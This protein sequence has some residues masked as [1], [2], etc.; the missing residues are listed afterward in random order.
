RSRKVHLPLCKLA[1]RISGRPTEERMKSI[2]CHCQTG[3][4]VE[5]SHVEMERSIFFNIDEVLL[6]QVDVAGLSI[7]R[8]AHHFILTGIDLEAGVIGKRG[9]KQSKRMGK[10]DLFMDHQ[11]IAVPRKYR[12]GYPFTHPVHGQERSLFKRRREKCG[13]G[14]ADMV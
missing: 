12:N 13:G 11:L 4:V 14:V 10:V 8:Q 5:I 7:R 1:L 3:T 2:V 6:D 9:V